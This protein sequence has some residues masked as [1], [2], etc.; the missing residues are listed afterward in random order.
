MIPGEYILDGADLELNAGHP[1]VTISVNNTGDRHL[2][3]AS[4]FVAGPMPDSPPG[5]NPAIRRAVFR[6]DSGE[7]CIRRCGHPSAVTAELVLTAL[8]LAARCAAGPDAP[9]WLLASGGACSQPLVLNPGR[10]T[11]RLKAH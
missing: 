7:N 3:S 10:L 9:P 2:A 11:D 4:L 6:L 1:V 5:H 8:R